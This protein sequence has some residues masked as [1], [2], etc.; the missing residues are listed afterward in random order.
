M[1]SNFCLFPAVKQN[2]GG[3]MF[4]GDGKMETFVTWWLIT[5]HRLLLALDSADDAINSLSWSFHFFIS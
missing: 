1:S 3:L 5:T 2:L 4:K